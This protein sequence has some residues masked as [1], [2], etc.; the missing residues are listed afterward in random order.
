MCVGCPEVH[1]PGELTAKGMSP[2]LA[3]LLVAGLCPSLPGLS[4]G[5]SEPG[6]AAPKT[7]RT[8]MPVD[9]LRLV[10]S[11][12][13]FAFS[14]YKH[15]A[16]KSPK[17]NVVF[18]PLS[19]STAL[20]F[21]SLGARGTTH[22]ELL[23]GLK[24]NLT[25]TPEAEI[26]RGFQHLLRALHRPGNAL[27][28]SVGNAMFVDQS[29]GLL[30]K[31]KADAQA[32]YAAEAFSTNF[33]DTAASEQLINQ[34]VEKKTQGK[35][36][37]LV[38]GLDPHT[39]MVLV[40]YIFLKGQWK[41]PFDPNATFKTDFRVSKSRSVRVSM[42]NAEDLRAP[43]FRDEVLSCA[44]L[45]LPY[46]GSASA[47]LVLP[48][49]GKMKKVEAALLPET[50]K[51]WS[52]SLQMSNIDELFLP[53]FSISSNYEL[54]KILPRLGVRRAFTHKADFSGV[55]GDKKLK[56]SQVVH[57]AV[58]DVAENGTEAA[59]ATAIK[60]VPLSGKLGPLTIL[61]FNRPFLMAIICKDTQSVLFLA[62]V[63][64]PRQG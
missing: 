56:V 29:Q 42:M 62:K 45:E 38:S 39:A 58:L 18:S 48:D 2:L 15:L 28:L 3:L 8:H 60:M 57:K 20:A 12:T 13:D 23:R 22:R 43:Y 32:L 4:K 64:H 6:N 54:E 50:L 34:Y 1:L 63:V 53:K 33:R 52:A 17:K 21:L 51:R 55:T 10:S 47:L 11:N 7:P 5:T 44:V 61:N 14:L 31:F 30:H 59:A 37:D 25:E 46:V 24:F 16:S 19:V 35:I 27:Q 41:M 26:H 36:V 40:N 9:T 49:S